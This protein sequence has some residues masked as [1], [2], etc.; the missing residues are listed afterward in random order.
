M[1]RFT[2]ALL[3]WGLAPIVFAQT[4]L[5]VAERI[6][7]RELLR[8]P[9]ATSFSLEQKNVRPVYA[10]LNVFLGFGLDYTTKRNFLGWIEEWNRK[11]GVKYVNLF[12]VDNIE[13][14][15]LVLARY[16]ASEMA[17]EVATS[18]P[19]GKAV[20]VYDKTV[21]RQEFYTTVLAYILLPIPTT[22]LHF[23]VIWRGK[24]EIKHKASSASNTEDGWQL[25]NAFFRL[26]K[27][28]PK[29]R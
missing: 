21:A 10:S 5:D 11:Q 26:L 28:K 17:L 6:R 13:A 16:P 15:H 22:P 23:Q 27:Q 2:L 4:E 24:A 3:V 18:Q 12:I 7:L 19:A 8:V 14:A 25:R 1:Q 9:A 20:A 29:R